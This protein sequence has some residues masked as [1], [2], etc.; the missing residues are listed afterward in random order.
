MYSAPMV[1]LVVLRKQK[2]LLVS[3][4]KVSGDSLNLCSY[5]L[6]HIQE[7]FPCTMDSIMVE[8]NRAEPRGIPMT[9]RKLLA[10]LPTY[11]QGGSQHELD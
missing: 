5:V 1:C 3:F 10:E 6:C 8:E 11:I 2:R 7:Y 4:P 9:I